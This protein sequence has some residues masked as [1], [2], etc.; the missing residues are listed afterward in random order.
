[1]FKYQSCEKDLLSNMTKN[2]VRKDNK[3]NKLAKA[4][5][6]ISSAS[7]VFEAS[8]M[9]KEAD[10]LIS[11]L[12]KI[13]T[14]AMG[15]PTEETYGLSDEDYVNMYSGDVDTQL[16]VNKMLSK[17]LSPDEIAVRLG[18]KYLEPLAYRRLLREQMGRTIE[19]TKTPKEI[20]FNSKLLEENHDKNERR[21]SLRR[22]ISD[23]ITKSPSEGGEVS[24]LAKTNNK[25][26]NSI[27]QLIKN[28]ERTGTPFAFDGN[29]LDELDTLEI[30]D[31]DMSDI[32][33]INIEMS[34]TDFE[35][36][37]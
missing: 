36:E 8:G 12:E 18:D 30:D 25:I 23:L 10:K 31:Q 3:S 21:E 14:H 11:I 29:D 17:H 19:K 15:M 33:N 37:D 7:E 28:M 34:E 5:E 35:D 20:E 32:N 24:K 9:T 27:Q 13:A 22:E 1:M 4:I 16:K 6:L 26:K 2:L